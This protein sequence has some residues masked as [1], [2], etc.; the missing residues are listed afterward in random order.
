MSNIL[1]P[2]IFQGFCLAAVTFEL[3][4]I[5][6][7]LRGEWRLPDA[8]SW[9]DEE[10]RYSNNLALTYVFVAFLAVLVAARTMAFFLP[11]LRIIVVYN[12]VLH[13]IELV[14]F[15]YCFF[16]KQDE[17][18]VSAY[19]IGALMTANV[20]IFIARLL[21]LEGQTKAAEMANLKW[22]QEQLTIIRQK[23]AAYAKEKMEK[24]EN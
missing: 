21:Y 9:F 22:R 8:G 12:A 16:N 5:V 4:V 1:N 10:A 14:L 19:A 2:D 15:L 24:K 11:N 6:Q 18:N 7:L 23:R 13:S 17:S 3:P 20:V